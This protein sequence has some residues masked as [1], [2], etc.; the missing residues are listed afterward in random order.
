MLEAKTLCAIFKDN[1][2]LCNDISERFVQDFIHCIETNGRHVIYLKFLRTIVK[3]EGQVVRK[4]QNMVMQELISSGDEVLVFYND[5]TSFA[6]LVEMMRSEKHQ[7]D[8]FGLLHY[9]INLGIS[10]K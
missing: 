7:L 6:N 1:I 10:I 5:K 4:C 9:H 8:E 3:T 2:T